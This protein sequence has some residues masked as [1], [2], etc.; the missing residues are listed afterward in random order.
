MMARLRTWELLGKLKTAC[1]VVLG[2]VATGSLATAQTTVNTETEASTFKA[3][4]A[5]CHGEDGS[6]S[7]LGSRLHVKDLRSK[8]VQDKSARELEQTVRA[9]TG[10]MPAFGSRLDS[11]QIQK[12]IE[13]IQQKTP[14]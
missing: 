3:N 5:I 2:I 6:G 4:C 8:E 11:E 9:G 10:N 7:V 13:Y 1:L 12:L 14:K